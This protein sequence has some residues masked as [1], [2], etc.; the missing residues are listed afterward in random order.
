MTNNRTFWLDALSEQLRRWPPWLSATVLALYLFL[1]FGVA[2]VVGAL[3][4]VIGEGLWR[5]MLL[6]SGLTVYNLLAVPVF[7]SLHDEIAASLRP[8]SHLSDAEYAAL[9]A[10]AEERNP[11]VE[12]IA[13]G[14]GL[15]AQVI[16]FGPPDTTQP[17][18]LYLFLS[19]LFMFGTL[20]WL[21]YRA[22][23]STRLSRRLSRQPL[24]VDI[25]DIRPFEPIGR[26]SLLLSMVFIGGN[27]IGVVL[28]V[29]WEGFLK[30][31]SLIVYTVVLLITVFVFFFGMWPTH[32][33]LSQTK[34]GHLQNAV[35]NIATAYRD[36]VILKVQNKA[37]GE[38]E[39]EVYTWTV[40][41]K[42]LQATR[43]W[44]YNT[45]MLRTLVITVLTPIAVGLSKIA[46]VLLTSGRPQW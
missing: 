40:L 44:P 32:R 3:P 17:L 39:S 38:A 41:E 19:F 7:T 23:A 9:V 11:G 21:V 5:I 43:T 16:I 45:E 15:A 2:Y 24:D 34:K 27:I 37:T 22:V 6:A 18:D 35:D 13:F 8:L 10:G 26:Q 31:E 29:R 36:L 46:S 20:G 4:V 28:V 14:I 1:P 25:F 33:L 30:W 42:R 12:W